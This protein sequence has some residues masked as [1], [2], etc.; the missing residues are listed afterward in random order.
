M[1]RQVNYV[2]GKSDNSTWERA[3]QT[4]RAGT[5]WS[6]TCRTGGNDPTWTSSRP[7]VSSTRVVQNRGRYRA[8]LQGLL[9]EADPE[10]LKTVDLARDVVH[11]E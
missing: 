4:A 8:H 9:G 2:T 5:V 10:R 1:F 6:R 7:E 11:G 3:R